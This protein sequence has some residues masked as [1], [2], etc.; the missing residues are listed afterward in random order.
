MEMLKKGINLPPQGPS[1]TP[2]G[3]EC[4]AIVPG[5]AS[6]LSDYGL[7]GMVLQAS[8]ATDTTIAQTAHVIRASFT[9]APR[10]EESSETSH[11]K[12][13]Y[14]RPRETTPDRGSMDSGTFAAATF[15]WRTPAENLPAKKKRTTKRVRDEHTRVLEAATGTM[16]AAL[17]IPGVSPTSQPRG[18]RMKKEED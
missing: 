10:D 6:S 16:D 13:Y 7:S 11:S 17:T 4:G 1:D 8:A 5:Q 18:K 2:E 9:E 3:G 12:A 14:L 15:R